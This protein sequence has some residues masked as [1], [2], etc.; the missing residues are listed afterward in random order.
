M[1]LGRVAQPI[2]L[3]FAMSAYDAMIPLLYVHSEL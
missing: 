1:V 3:S 2:D